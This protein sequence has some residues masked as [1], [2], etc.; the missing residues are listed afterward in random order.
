MRVKNLKLTGSEHFLDNTKR[1]Y[2]EYDTVDNLIKNDLP[3]NM[4]ISKNNKF[5]VFYNPP[6][7]DKHHAKVVIFIKNLDE[8]RLVITFTTERKRGKF[9]D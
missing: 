5:L 8:I 4:E 9:H 7:S 1:K 6:E 3:V 2:C